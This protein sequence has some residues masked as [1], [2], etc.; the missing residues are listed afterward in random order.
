MELQK[1]KVKTQP[2]VFYLILTLIGIVLAITGDYAMAGVNLSL[3]LVFDPFDP[4]VPFPKRPLGQK[5][6]LTGQL[7]LA[8]GLIGIK[9]VHIIQ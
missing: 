9:I 8:L 1:S 5:V 3:A 2:R 4:T 6:L 7:F